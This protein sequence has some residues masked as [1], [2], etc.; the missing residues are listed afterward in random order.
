MAAPARARSR[1]TFADISSNNG[2][3][4]ARA[5]AAA[6]HLLI[7]IKAT[8]STD[9]TTPLYSAW[10]DAAHEARL[11]V[12]HYHFAHSDNGEPV[13][14]AR[15]FWEHVRPHFHPRTDRLAID[16]ETG[17]PARW[18]AWLSAFDNE[19]HR[20][21]TLEAIGYCFGWALPE[22]KLR[23][24]KFWIPSW[25]S[26]QPSGAFRRVPGGTLWGWQYTNGV[27]DPA[28]GPTTAAGIPGRCDMS[29]LSPAI[30]RSLGRALKR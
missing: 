1:E 6:G 7:A 22:L 15:Y 3:F 23:S 16:L 13:Q 21:S 24:G 25:G 27:T 14:E 19:L 18:P 12:L 29:V 8:E 10:V 9:F 11:G 28:G 5:Y 26:H 2:G 4:N 20:Y 30:V 17:A